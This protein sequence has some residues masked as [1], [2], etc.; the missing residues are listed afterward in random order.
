[1]PQ[2]FLRFSAIFKN[3]RW[4][5]QLNFQFPIGH[6]LGRSQLIQQFVYLSPRK[7]H[8]RECEAWNWRTSTAFCGQWRRKRVCGTYSREKREISIRCSK[9]STL[10]L[11]KASRSFQIRMILGKLF[12]FFISMTP[13]DAAKT[14]NRN[15]WSSRKLEKHSINSAQ[16]CPITQSNRKLIANDAI[17]SVAS[18]NRECERLYWLR[19]S[20]Q[21]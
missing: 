16:E 1:M 11:H 12:K 7:H 10:K 13:L 17:T 18:N 4:L 21:A 5:F 14:I 15:C 3:C 2:H 9:W 20:R 19:L 6:A 8:Y